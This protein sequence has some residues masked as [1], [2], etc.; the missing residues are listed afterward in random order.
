METSEDEHSAKNRGENKPKAIY[1]INVILISFSRSV[2][3][4]RTKYLAPSW[5]GLISGKY[6]PVQT[7]H[8]V[9]KPLVFLTHSLIVNCVAED[10]A[11]GRSQRCLSAA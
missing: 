1:I 8:S 2:R 6:F 9:N 4:F 10:R 11:C 7:S 5:L 3:F